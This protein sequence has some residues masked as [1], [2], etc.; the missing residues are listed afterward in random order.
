MDFNKDVF[1]NKT[2]LCPCDDPEWSNFTKYF[3]LNFKKLGLKKLICTSFARDK[4]NKSFEI[5]PS[6]LET[7]SDKF[8][9]EKTHS[10][11]K[12]FNLSRDIDNSGTIDFKDIEWNYLEGDGDFRS[13]EVTKL[14]SES[15]FVVTNPPFSLFREFVNWVV[16]A[17][18]KFLL[19]GNINCIAYKEIFPLLDRK[20]V[21]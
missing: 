10:H 11:G 17:N 18:K 19:I 15:D 6:D 12:V 2:V 20:S 16:K 13:D 1:R 21:V 7:K 9:P 14:L 3:A 8:D 4:K 5:K